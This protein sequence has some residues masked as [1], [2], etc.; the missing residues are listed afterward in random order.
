MSKLL[1]RFVCRRVG[2]DPVFVVR[3]SIPSVFKT[4]LTTCKRCGQVYEETARP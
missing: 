4:Y 1:D 3:C 2:H